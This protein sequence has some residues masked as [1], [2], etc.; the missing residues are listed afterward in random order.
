[1]IA[2]LKASRVAIPGTA[3][4]AAHV[5]ISATGLMKMVCGQR[6]SA[7]EARGHD[8]SWVMLK[9]GPHMHEC[10]I[11]STIEAWYAFRE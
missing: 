6:G 10:F 7:C 9:A 5:E 2:E 3:C 8:R 4:R 11:A 1:M